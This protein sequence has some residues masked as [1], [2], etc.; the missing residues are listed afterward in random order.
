MSM[1]VTIPEKKASKPNS[2]F[3]RIGWFVGLYV[4]GVGSVGI[5]A[6]GLRLWIKH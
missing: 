4:L 6:Y 3:H 2:I 1:P 5:V